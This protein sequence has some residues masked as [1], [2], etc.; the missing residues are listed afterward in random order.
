MNG[1]GGDGFKVILSEKSKC[2]LPFLCDS[3][4]LSLVVAQTT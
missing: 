4:S 1:E 3:V 2:Y